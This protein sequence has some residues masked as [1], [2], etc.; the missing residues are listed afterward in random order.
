M[1]TRFDLGLFGSHNSA[2]AIAIDGIVKE[3][4]ELER[5][6]GLKNAAFA[7]HFPIDN[8]KDVLHDILKYFKVKYNVDKYQT[9]AYNCDN[10]LHKTIEC[11]SAI[12]VP[13]HTAHCAN[14]LYQSPY[15]KA[16]VVSFDGGSEEGFF[17]IF[18]AERNKDPELI[19]SVGI[20][21]CVTYA[22]VAHYCYPIKREDNWWWG[23]LVYAGKIMGLAGKGKVRHEYVPKFKSFYLGQSVDNVNTA[24]ER[25]QKLDINF[26]PEDMA[27]TSQYVFESIF[28]DIIG[29]YKSDLPVCFAGGGAMN[30]INN[31]KHNAF[32]SPNPDDRGIAL[33][34]LLHILKPEYTL[35]S[36]YIGMPFQ[37]EKYNIKTPRELALLLSEEKIIGLVQGRSEHGA[38]ALGNRSILCLPKKGM[39]DKL[40]SLVKFREPFRPFS[41]LCRVED[42]DKWFETSKFTEWMSHNA[43]VVNPNENIQDII[44]FDNTARLQTIT[45]D[46]NTYLYETLTELGKLGIEPIVINTSF[47]KQGKPILNTFE[48][49]NWMLNNTG[50]D[51]LII[52]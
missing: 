21:L 26:E 24:H 16:L 9:V 43:F 40:N 1:N 13:H 19:T 44:H 39:K 29:G 28:N 36:R 32:V 4:V 52:L 7:F 48:E 5:W 3:V 47:N 27:A 33:G 49:A 37:G 50:L 11:Q 45:K 42:K 31:S 8:P 6:I 25:F 51:E 17:K 20:D 46:S 30:I 23:N 2:V 18:N 41:P 35:D 34:C 12:Y 22:A 38:R 14:V 10:D 15:N